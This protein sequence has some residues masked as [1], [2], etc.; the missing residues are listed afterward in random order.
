MI[1]D[2]FTYPI[3]GK[4]FVGYKDRLQLEFFCIILDK[5]SSYKRTFSHK[6]K[7][8]KNPIMK[9]FIHLFRP[10]RRLQPEKNMVLY[11]SLFFSLL[12]AWCIMTSF[13][14]YQNNYIPILVSGMFLT[15]IYIPF[16]KIKVL[17]NRLRFYK[18][19]FNNDSAHFMNRQ[20][21]EY[22]SITCFWKKLRLL[23]LFVNTS[24]ASYYPKCSELPFVNEIVK[25][26]EDVTRDFSS[27][28]IRA[29]YYIK[30]DNFYYN[31]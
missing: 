14:L 25:S 31:L 26:V 24:N 5:Y 11:L 16:Q 19:V 10:Y 30:E 9:W 27:D 6:R 13:Y 8:L 21:F 15:F 12:I 1:K 4:R 7:M 3:G 2:E 28:I 23:I 18:I 22:S 20:M 17:Y 29:K